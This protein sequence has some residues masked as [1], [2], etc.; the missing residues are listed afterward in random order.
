[1][2]TE[3]FFEGH[4][5]VF[6]CPSFLYALEVKRQKG[7]NVMIEF[8]KLKQFIVYE[9]C[10][11]KVIVPCILGELG[12]SYSSLFCIF[13]LETSKSLNSNMYSLVL[14]IYFHRSFPL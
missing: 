6:F 9:I 4:I 14:D 1:M 8:I 2:Y 7:L 3:I 12:I 11:R 5:Q 13:V 10:L